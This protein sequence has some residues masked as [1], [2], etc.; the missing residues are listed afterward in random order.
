MS[1]HFDERLE[2]ACVR[3]EPANRGEGEKQE[4]G[5]NT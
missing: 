4:G 1:G 5:K 2:R 3:A